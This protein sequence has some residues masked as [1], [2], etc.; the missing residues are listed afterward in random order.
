MALIA[1]HLG[2]IDEEQIDNMSYIFFEAV[3]EELGHKLTYDAV[4]NYAGNSFAK[5]SWDMIMD[6]NPMTLDPNG[7]NGGRKQQQTLASFLGNARIATKDDLAKMN[8]Y[9]NKGDKGK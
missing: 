4:V 8:A 1:T 9:S 6:T 2:V 7:R 3:L 5:D